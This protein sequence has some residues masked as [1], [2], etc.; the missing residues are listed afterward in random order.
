MHP[1]QL[2]SGRIERD[3]GAA[4]SGGGVDHAVDHQRRAFQLVFGA[5]ADAVGLET[6]RHFEL[7]EVGSVDLIERPV[8]GAGEIRRVGRPLGVLG[9]P[10]CGGSAGGNDEGRGQRK[11]D[12]VF[13]RNDSFA[14]WFASIVR[15]LP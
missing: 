9:M 11:I 2:A 15:A 13:I 4:R 7:V 14:T 12:V 8:A 1:Q 5:I 3:G 10:L 6:P